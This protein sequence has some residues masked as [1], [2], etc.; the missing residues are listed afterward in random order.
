[1]A[2]KQECTHLA[3]AELYRQGSECCRNYSN[4]TMR[5]RTLAQQVLLAYAVGVGLLLTRGKEIG[6]LLFGAGIILILFSS[7]LWILN[8]HYS[9]SFTGIRNDC[10]RKL[11]ANVLEAVETDKTD[12]PI[13]VGP[14]EAHAHAQPAWVRVAAWHW[15]YLVLVFVGLLTMLLGVTW[16]VFDIS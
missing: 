5:V 6:A 13:A 12:K 9:L 10:L 3:A 11:E 16:G 4:L 15:P 8:L 14:W 7:A 1:M 2:N